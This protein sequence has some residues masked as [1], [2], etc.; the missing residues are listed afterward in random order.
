MIQGNGFTIKESKFDYFFGRVTSSPSNEARSR[1]NL[2]DLNKLGIDE[3]SN[4]QER[5]MN[6]FESGLTAL[7]IKRKVNEYGITIIKQIEISGNDVKGVIEIAY[8]YPA[9]NLLGIPEV[10]TI[11]PKISNQE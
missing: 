4:G 9:G 5:L 8:F 10:T 2:Q 11:I 6:I 7:E 1:Q 3:A